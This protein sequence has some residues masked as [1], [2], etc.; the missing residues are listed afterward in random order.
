MIGKLWYRMKRAIVHDHDSPR[1][2][3]AMARRVTTQERVADQTRE[4]ALEILR[5]R[6]TIQAQVLRGERGYDRRD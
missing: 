6:G 3:R 2:T 5:S 1:E 4:K